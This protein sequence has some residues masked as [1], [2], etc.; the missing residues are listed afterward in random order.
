MIELGFIAG[1]LTT[2]CWLPQ[3]VRTWRLHRADEISSGYL[4]VLGSGIACWVVYGLTVRDMAIAVTNATTLV[5]VLG[6]ATLKV[7]ARTHDG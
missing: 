5:L 4:T 7:R 2:V 6:L 3:L 1:A